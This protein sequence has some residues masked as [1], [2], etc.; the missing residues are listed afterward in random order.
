MSSYQNLAARYDALTEDVL[1]QK[2]AAYL[3]RWLRKSAIPVRS[4]LDLACGTGTLAC[5]LAN[6][7][8]QLIATDASEE[9]LTQASGKT[10]SVQNGPP[11]LFLHQS[12]PRL[13]L[14]QPVDAAICTLDALNYLTRAADL[15]ETF[16]RVFR[17]LRPGGGF[18]FDVNTPYKLQR[19]DRQI[20][21]DETED[22]VCVW[23]TFFSQARKIC[24]YQVDLFRLRPDG[25]WERS[26][27]EHRE[28][29]WTESELREALESA[30]FQNIRLY[31]DLSRQPPASDEDRWIFTAV[32]K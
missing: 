28:R 29:A 24:T 3:L 18:C 30:G 23:R 20:Y 16:R 27:E 15:W 1:Y 7:G 4:I 22:S 25:A 32:K 14:L 6:E 2:R 19:M 5:A 10:P 9:M 13:R 21:M 8:Y 31:G 11:P 26:F 17:W 12:M